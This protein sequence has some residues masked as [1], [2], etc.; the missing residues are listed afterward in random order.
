[1][2]GIFEKLSFEYI[3]IHNNFKLSFKKYRKKNGK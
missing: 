3:L 2:D 1:M